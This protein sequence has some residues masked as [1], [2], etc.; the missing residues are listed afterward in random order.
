MAISE[1]KH[2]GLTDYRNT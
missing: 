2:Y 1:T